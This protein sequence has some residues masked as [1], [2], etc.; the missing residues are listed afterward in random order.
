MISI[1]QDRLVRQFMEFVQIDSPSFEE[2]S[3]ASALTEELNKL[4]LAVENDQ[5]GQ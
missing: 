1:S 4:G 3:F 5:T 2:A